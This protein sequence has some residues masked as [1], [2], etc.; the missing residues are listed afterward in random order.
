M[1]KISKMLIVIFT[2]TV[3]NVFE[4]EEVD[5]GVSSFLRAGHGVM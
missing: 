4:L 5:R 3:G 2:V 1:A